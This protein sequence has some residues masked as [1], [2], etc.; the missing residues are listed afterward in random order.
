MAETHTPIPKP[1]VDKIVA[2]SGITQ[3]G[4]ASIREIKKMINDIEEASGT[5]FIRMEMGIP[6]LPAC[7]IGIDAQIEALKNGCAALYPDIEGT[8]AL[9][10]EMSC[11]V[12]NFLDLDVSPDGCIPTVG[13]M[14]GGMAGFMTFVRTRKERDT[15]LFIDPGFPVQKQQHRVLGLKFET[16]DVYNFRGD[17]L[18]EKLVSYLEKGNIHSIIYS[19]PNNPSWICFTEKELKVIGELA[20]QYDVCVFED[21]AYFG[22]DFRRDISQPGKPPFQPTVGK[23]TDNYALLISSSKAFSYAGER[24]GML[25]LSD[26]LYNREFPDLIPYFGTPK[27][28]RAIIY[29]T[30]YAISSG[31]SHSAQYA[32]AAILKACNEGT[33][34]YLDE[35]KIYA[36]KARIM[37][38]MFIENGFKI[39][40]DKDED[41]PL[42]DGFYFTVSYPGLS[43]EE[44]LREFLYY[45]VSAISLAIT[46]SER[47]EGLRACVS[48]I[49]M[50]QLPVLE[51]RLR[52]F[53]E[54]H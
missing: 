2:E 44:L 51:E 49:K 53:R 40:Y 46:G 25:V 27:L 34:N 39:V 12:K 11:Y 5:K 50:E 6:G 17:K 33:Y 1:I 18:R 38:R 15:T 35:V 21:L 42:A 28:G 4:R 45:G 31:T 3:V 26:H 22:M 10:K 14:M 54:N 48:L 32:L 29:G 23:Y 8:P 9:K 47:T 43:G 13:S 37:K 36:E 52:C 16:F 7:K 41:L 19:N 30:V 20:T 24:I